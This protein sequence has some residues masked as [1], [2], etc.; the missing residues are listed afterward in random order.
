M[1]SPIELKRIIWVKPKLVAEIKYFVATQ[2]GILR[3][4]VFLRL[5]TDKN[6][7]DC[8]LDQLKKI[9]SIVNI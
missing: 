4:S 1:E 5:R 2:S 8:G 9:N 7:H 6:V 3:A